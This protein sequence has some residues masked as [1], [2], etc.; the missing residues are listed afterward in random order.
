[1]IE[2]EVRDCRGGIGNLYGLGLPASSTVKCTH[3]QE[4]RVFLVTAPDGYIEV[5]RDNPVRYLAVAPDPETGAM[6]PVMKVSVR[7]NHPWRAW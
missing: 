2:G 5:F 7:L 4:K 1:M 3:D 6:K